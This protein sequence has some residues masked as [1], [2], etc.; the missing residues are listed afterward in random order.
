MRN[1]FRIS[2]TLASFMVL[3]ACE[4]SPPPLTE[5]QKLIGRAEEEVRDQLNDPTSAQFK[6]VDGSVPDKC[7]RGK[8]LGK[9]AFGAFTGYRSFVW[10][11]NHVK[12]EPEPG[13]FRAT[14]PWLDAF[15]GC[16][17]LKFPDPELPTKDAPKP[18]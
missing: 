12:F 1:I 15:I 7:V 9:N 10:R 16:M 3:T 5:E 8:V 13:D 2:A 14:I 4:Q 6:D 18:R 11:P 17:K